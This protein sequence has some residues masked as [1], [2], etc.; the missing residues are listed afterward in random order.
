MVVDLA[1]HFFSEN[2]FLTNEVSFEQYIYLF[3]Y[4]KSGLCMSCIE[5]FLE[6]T[7]DTI[8]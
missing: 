1:D 6:D 4:S 8:P 5:K 7:V 2:N 3:L